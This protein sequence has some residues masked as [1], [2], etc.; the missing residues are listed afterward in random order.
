MRRLRAV[1]GRTGALTTRTGRSR[2][3]TDEAR[4]DDDAAEAQRRV[5]R[6][7]GDDDPR[8]ALGRSSSRLM[9]VD[10]VR[11]GRRLT[12]LR[13]VLGPF[14]GHRFGDLTIRELFQGE[15]WRTLTATF[16]H[17]GLLHIGLNLWALYQLGS[18]VESWYGAGPFVA[19]YVLTG[20]RRQPDLGAASAARSRHPPFVAL[21][22]AA[23]RS[24]WGW[25]AL[26]AV[27]GWRSRTRIG[28]HLRDADGL[29]PGA[30]GRAG[31][32]ALGC[33][34]AGDRQLGPRRGRA[35]RRGDR[36][37][38]PR[39]CVRQAGRL[40]A[41][42]AGV[43]GGCSCSRPAPA[44]WSPTTAPRP[45]RAARPLEQARRRLAADEPLIVRLEKRPRGLPDGRRAR[46]VIVRGLA[47]PRGRPGPA[48]AR[49]ARPAPDARAGLAAPTPTRSSR[50]PVLDAGLKY[51]T[52]MTGDLD[53][54][55]ERGRLPPGPQAP[56]ARPCSS[57]RRWTRS[58]SSTT[59]S[60]RSSARRRRDRR[61]VRAP[62]RAGRA[63]TRPERRRRIAAG[64]MIIVGSRPSVR[65]ARSSAGP[66][67]CP[68]RPD[69]AWRRGDEVGEG[70]DRAGELGVVAADDV[71]LVAV[72]RPGRAH[73]RAG[74]GAARSCARV[75]GV[76]LLLTSSRA[77]NAGPCSA[78]IASK[79][80][81]QRNGCA[82]T[83][84][85][86]WRRTALSRSFS[87]TPGG[88]SSRSGRP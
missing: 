17:Y 23:R 52:S 46:A 41:R 70:G 9:V 69:R 4:A 55:A 3:R 31:D 71:G 50:P 6:V 26:C 49:A 62:G 68:G 44:R 45:A 51:L 28:E 1:L 8:R 24:S 76:T 83:T 20:G 18:L 33:G 48:R 35:R 39:R 78:T 54:R 85:A 29:G 81:S 88:T 25:S 30:D 56:R 38:E 84:A 72:A 13:F 16:V 14:D 86:P 27:V 32:R 79:S 47:R 73:R 61:R 67:R 42:L 11:R 43:L 19:I 65:P 10:Q 40:A 22:R 59:G 74:R 80:W 15:V 82:A 64:S 58:A 37:G 5:P 34:P 36:A 87:A 60:P 53:T 66:G 57:R 77:S 2:T 63:V 7:P 21:R 75:S 12:A